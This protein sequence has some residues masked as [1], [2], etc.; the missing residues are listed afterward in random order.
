[1]IKTDF[2]SFFKPPLHRRSCNMP[3]SKNYPILEFQEKRKFYYTKFLWRNCN[4][5]TL[6]ASGQVDH[7]HSNLLLSFD[8]GAFH[9]EHLLMPEGEG[10]FY[11]NFTSSCLIFSA[12][13]SA[14]FLRPSR[15]PFNASTSA[16]GGNRELRLSS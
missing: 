2:R 3:E 16:C 8:Q 5:D 12:T 15:T 7:G 1:M 11:K 13:S 6:D 4:G 14:F 10:R 9:R